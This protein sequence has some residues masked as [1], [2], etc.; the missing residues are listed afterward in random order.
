[1]KDQIT[2][3][4]LDV[5]LGLRLGVG[6]ARM[7][8]YGDYIKNL[9]EAKEAGLDVNMLPMPLLSDNVAIGM[10][11]GLSAR[12]EGGVNGGVTWQIVELGGSFS[13]EQQQGIKIKT[14][15]S[16]KSIGSPDL[17]KMQALSVEELKK[18]LEVVELES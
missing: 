5:L 8:E 17:T 14:D 7:V 11:A 18:L 16:F 4:A 1:M 13:R 12:S 3:I 6:N 15:M 9:I 10:E 2:K